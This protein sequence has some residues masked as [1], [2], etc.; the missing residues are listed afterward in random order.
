M[1]HPSGDATAVGNA[2]S[3][4]CL[5]TTQIQ[6]LAT[7]TASLTTEAVN[8]NDAKRKLNGV[9]TVHSRGRIIVICSNHLVLAG[10]SGGSKGMDGFGIPKSFETNW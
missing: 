10:G 2:R 5:A 7:G 4:S 9:Q 1:S 6:R 8:V 3:P